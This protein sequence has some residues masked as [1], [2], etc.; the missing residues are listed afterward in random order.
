MCTLI[1]LRRP[2]HDW[3]L[4]LAANREEMTGRPWL[5]PARHWPEYPNVVAGFDQLAGGSWLG[6]NDEGVIAIVMNRHGSLGPQAGRR[7]RGELVLRALAYGR[8]MEAA[9]ALA[10]L[11]PALYR[12]FNLVVADRDNAVW[13]CHRGEEKHHR[14]EAQELMSGISMLT[15]RD[16]NDPRSS[17]IR[18]YLPRFREARPPD[19]QSADGWS[20][21]TALLV[22]LVLDPTSDPQS[23]MTVVSQHGF[24]TLSSSLIALPAA[25]REDLRPSWLFASHRP[26]RTEYQPVPL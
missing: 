18:S 23:T 8:A 3:P 9:S 12:S 25:T 13:L 19:P 10:E 26:A 14:I 6:L 1:L 17:R 16:C 11:K 5:P 20:E 22:S 21:W 7:S 24:A 4:L 15:N 2:D